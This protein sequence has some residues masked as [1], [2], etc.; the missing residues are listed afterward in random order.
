MNVSPQLSWQTS[1][2][3][4]ANL[5]HLRAAGTDAAVGN[6]LLKHKVCHHRYGVGCPHLGLA[7]AVGG[8]F[9]INQNHKTPELQA[10][11]AG[12]FFGTQNSRTNRI[13]AKTL[14]NLFNRTV[15]R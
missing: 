13:F 14:R 8:Y 15:C 1:F 2:K 7:P 11:P 3:P 4:A 9:G 12:H 6:A 5:G 10:D